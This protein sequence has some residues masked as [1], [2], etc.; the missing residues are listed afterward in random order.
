MWKKAIPVFLTV[1]LLTVFCAVSASADELPEG[2]SFELMENIV[3]TDSEYTPEG[4]YSFW[5][6]SPSDPHDFDLMSGQLNAV[7]FVYPDQP[8]TSQ[9]EAYAALEELGLIDIA[10]A[11]PAY[12]IIPNPLNGETYT[13]ADL[14]VYYESQIYL[15]GGK[16]I[17]YTPPTGEYE[18]CTYNN[19]QYIIAEGSGATF[20]NNVLSQNA[21]RIAGILSFG[22][23]MD[24]NLAEGL[25]LPAYLVNATSTAVN[26]YKQ[27]N[28]TD[29]EPENGHFVNSSYTEKQVYVADGTDSFDKDMIA[30]AW[31]DMLSRLTRAPLET[32]VVTNT[33]DMTEWVLM[34]WP[35]YDELG[36]DLIEHTYTNTV[37]DEDGT[38]TS[39]DYVIYDY[40]PE[41]YTG[42]E[43]VPLVILL[44]GYSEDPLCPGAT[45]GWA[46]KAAEEGFILVAPDYVNDLNSTGV[47][48]DCVMAALEE[49]LSRYNIDES[50]IYL[51]GF[52][53]GGMSTMLTGFANAD[54]FAAIAPM[55]GMAD[56]R[57]FQADADTYDLPTFVLCGTVDTNN[58]TTDE[59]GNL[60][61][62]LMNG[63]IYPYLAAFNG[64]TFGD[65]DYT[66]NMWGYAAD[67]SRSLVLQ[68][69]NYY[70][71][72]YYADGY[73]NPMLEFVTVENVAHACSDVYADLA[74][75]YMSQF[76]RGTDG[77]VVELFD[78]VSSDDYFETAVNWA[79]VQGITNG[80]TATTFSP[81]ET[82][83]RA[84]AVTFLYRAA[85]SPAVEGVENPFTDVS[86]T[87]YYY[88]AVLW[89][90]SKG[91]T[92]GT[93]ETTFS[94]NETCE[95]CQIVTFLYRYYGEPAVSGAENPFTDVKETDYYYNAVL[96]AC[97]E[98]VTNGTT[99]TTFSPHEECERCEFV[100]FLYR[101]F[102]GITSK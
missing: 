11:T 23:E 22:G 63:N 97:S 4:D 62:T 71:Y 96:W 38:E 32:N 76:A 98:A 9:E 25:A 77:S 45:C 65:P 29:S 33:A 21:G 56:I 3:V 34:S 95:R 60:T 28:E 6:Y 41:S 49:T 69:Y 19:L 92:T 30:T 44:H 36:L 14:D 66:I 39:T 61:A 5:L 58:N 46:E 1:L 43:A 68:G 102:T 87:E 75:E 12:I 20:V 10:E 26:Y 79:A 59:D 85:G 2:A 86:E 8:Y 35:N 37:T 84:Q 54:V 18:R 81:F 64:I 74:W 55:A 17:S 70:I 47:V 72:D 90:Y 53:M 78:D 82:C 31:A 57:S 91:I 88:N 50:R 51:T 15:A 13:E 52:S 24:E 94:P 101:A 83:T 100:S 67:E 80:T 16:I 99:E 89:A 42:D 40:V 73:T 93:T 48:I 27:V 7:I